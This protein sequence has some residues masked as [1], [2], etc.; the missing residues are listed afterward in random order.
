[1][2]VL[3]SKDDLLIY[4]AVSKQKGVGQM[5]NAVSVVAKTNKVV[6][7]VELSAKAVKA[8]SV[9]NKAKE[10]EAKAKALKSKAEA[11]LREALGESKAGIVEGIVAVRVVNGSNSHF[12]KVA[13]KEFLGEKE[14]AKATAEALKTTAYDYLRTL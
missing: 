10:A 2:L 4:K 6:E 11:I 14:Y 13:L 8:L 9:F 7:G 1:M 3:A 5:T 12:D